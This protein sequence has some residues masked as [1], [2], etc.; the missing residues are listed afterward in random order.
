MTIQEL[1]IASND[2]LLNA[3]AH[4]NEDQWRLA[5]PL[6]AA[7]KPTNLRQAVQY[8]TY[9]DAWV[10]DV[11]A[12]KTA[13]DVGDRYE[14]LLTN[15]DVIA[16]YRKYNQIASDAVKTL[17][18]DE[19]G[20][21]AHLSYGDFPVREYLQHIISFRAF[22][23]YDFAKLIGADAALDPGFVQALFDEF[24]PV[25][26]DYRHMGVF[27]PAI[28]VPADADLQTRLMAMVGRP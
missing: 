5:L 10:P 16:N 7:R 24:S 14:W 8:H 18:D 2:V 19:L 12:G 15:D 25:I 4:I 28:D 20:R 3:V 9:D 1:F 22:R 27:P 26:E 11:L 17:S 6:W 23:A 21:T 13:A